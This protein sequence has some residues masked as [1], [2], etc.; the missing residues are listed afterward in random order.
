MKVA[1]LNFGL[2]SEYR[3][4]T[5]EAKYILGLS[6]KILSYDAFVN[7]FILLGVIKCII[8]KIR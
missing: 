5:K 2:Q 3:V 8:Y 6:T 4:A 1:P 7:K